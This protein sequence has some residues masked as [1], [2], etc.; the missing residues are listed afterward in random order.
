MENVMIMKFII[1]LQI[2]V[3]ISSD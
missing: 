3:E 2:S 1:T